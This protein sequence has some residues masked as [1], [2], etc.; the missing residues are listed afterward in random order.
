MPQ[1]TLELANP[2]MPEIFRR[3]YEAYTKDPENGVHKVSQEMRKEHEAQKVSRPA[4]KN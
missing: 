2:K 3:Y 1:E 4:N